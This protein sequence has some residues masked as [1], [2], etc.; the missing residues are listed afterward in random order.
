MGQ[1]KISIIIIPQKMNLPF[2]TYVTVLKSSV[3]YKIK[4]RKEGITVPHR[5]V[6]L[7]D[8]SFS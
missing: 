4:Y 2:T 8:N 7:C 5:S 6:L 1:C 3:V